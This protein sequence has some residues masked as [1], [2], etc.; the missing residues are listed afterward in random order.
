VVRSRRIRGALLRLARRRG[1]SIA[2]GLALVL[3]SAWIEFS[4]HYSSWW[5]EGGAL[6]AGA[7]GLALIWTGLT[8]LGPDWVE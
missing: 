3:P 8:G 4:G 6:V 5:I 7:T 1:L 2:I